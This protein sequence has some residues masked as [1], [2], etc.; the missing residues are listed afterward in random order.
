MV[1]KYKNDLK[2]YSFSLFKWISRLMFNSN[3]FVFSIPAAM[4]RRQL[5]RRLVR[6]QCL[7]GRAVGPAVL[8]P[9]ALRFANA[10]RLGWRSAERWLPE[11]IFVAKFSVE[12]YKFYQL[13]LIAFRAGD[14][15]LLWDKSCGQILQMWF[16]QRLHVVGTVGLVIAFLQVRWWRFVVLK[17]SHD[18]LVLAAI[19]SDIV[20]VTVLYGQ[21][22][23][24]VENLQIVL[25]LGG[26]DPESEQH[27]NLPGRLILMPVSITIAYVA[28]EI[29]PKYGFTKFTILEDHVRHHE[30]QQ[31]SWTVDKYTR[32]CIK[33]ITILHMYYFRLNAEMLRRRNRILRLRRCCA[34]NHEDSCLY[35]KET[36]D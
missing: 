10:G 15:S 14:P 22:Q 20:D 16:V 18:P 30:P 32:I 12:R 13:F 9:T 34:K 35:F 25:A 1:Y 26:H 21:A 33:I 7:A 8:L 6:H 36:R 27:R 28:I 23:T 29:T 19:R 31:R 4:L 24:I 17:L 2:I 3:W 5:V 11:V